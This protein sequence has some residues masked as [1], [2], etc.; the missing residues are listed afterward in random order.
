[1]REHVRAYCCGFVSTTRARVRPRVLRT[2]LSLPTGRRTWAKVLQH[3]ANAAP[4][5]KQ[6]QRLGCKASSVFGVAPL[7]QRVRQPVYFSLDFVG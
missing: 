5:P 7:R 2:Y 6:R 1:M 4:R 3:I